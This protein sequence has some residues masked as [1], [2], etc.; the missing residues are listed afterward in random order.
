M[1]QVSIFSAFK[2]LTIPCFAAILIATGC[3]L[4]K[5]SGFNRG[6]QNITARYNILFNANEILRQKQESYATSFVDNYNEILSVYQ[7]T[8]PQTTTPDKDLELAIAK[9]N[10]IITIKEQSHYIGDAYLVLGK[11]NYLE[12]NYFNAVEYFSYVVRSFPKEKKLFQEGLIWKTR[13]LMYLNQ[14]A[15]A[16][17]VIDTA[18]QSINPKKRVNADIYA[19]KLQYDIDVQDYTDGE[20]MAKQAIRYC[21][22]ETQKLRWTFI[23]AQLQELNN[24]P[25]E[26]AANYS[27]IAK[28]NALFEMAFNASLNLIRIEDTQ[29]GVKIN[30]VDKLLGLLQN[31]N[32]KEFNDQIYYQAAQI[33]MAEKNIDQAIK[34][35]KLAIKA[36]VRN[37]DQKGLAYLR[38]AEI[39][40][41]NKA[42]YLRSKKYYDSTLTTLP[43]N[44]P[45]YQGIQKKS[46]NLALLA[47]RL[48]IITRED[49][50]QALARMDEKTRSALIDKMVDDE[51]LQQQAAANAAAGNASAGNSSGGPQGG[52]SRSGG[53]FYFDNATAVG[54]GFTDF[55]QKWGSRKPEDNW[56][57]STRSSS[58]ITANSAGS[59]Q[60]NDPDAP[61]NSA[62]N[63]KTTMNAGRY[64]KNLVQDLPL[65]PDLLAQSNVRVYNAYIDVG[66]FY[67]DI[68]DDKKEAI[69]T[70]ELVLRRFPDNPNNPAVYYSLYRLYSEVDP[71]KSDRYKNILLKNYAETPFAKIIS[72]PD[73]AKKLEDADAEFTQAYNI[74]FDL[75]AHKHYKEVIKSVPE[76]IKLY[77]DNKLS[78][79]LY[80]LRT[81]AAGH[82]EK[83]TPFRDSLQQ[84]T[85]KYPNDGLITPLVNK[86]LAYIDANQAELQA[87]NI[88]LENEDPNEVPFTLAQDLQEQAPYRHP[89]RPTPVFATKPGEGLPEKKPVAVA[90]NKPAQQVNVTPVNKPVI[91]KPDSATTQRQAVI[92]VDSVLTP[93]QALITKTDSVSKPDQTAINL[94]VIE[95]SIFSLNDST[96]YYFVVNVSSGTT[97]VAS[98]RFGIGQFNRANYAGKGI[99]HQLIV[100][101]GN[102]QLIF[103]GRFFSLDGVKDYARQII[104]LLPEIMKV[105]KDSYSFFII[106]QQ[107]LDKLA[108]KKTLDSYIDYY[109]KNY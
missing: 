19:T 41:N 101:E 102:N 109:Q 4:E 72:D 37:Q 36:G 46:S 34:Y 83:A 16:K 66:N 104:P 1:R 85:K 71:A 63:N 68:L 55:K 78:A 5:K 56:R 21:H 62:Q 57:R 74:V 7:D 15:E 25:R 98:S 92:K 58:D 64:R 17:P 9:G 24:K 50:L 94:P 100:V 32:N 47:D 23:L 43:T 73:Y 6:M 53:T 82:F 12:G 11:A 86:Q 18:I 67:R 81:I 90:A 54:Q 13:T 40:F 70:Y 28:S 3:S 84:L 31:P 45:G 69:S 107:N 93:G 29:N 42:D 39:Y 80:Y 35:Y 8:T 51:I 22:G 105:P 91:K 27:Q 60:A 88:V 96:N 10:R 76:L 79:Q 44:Y 103:V 52:I 48:Q 49:T 65:N 89:L 99:K 77:P 14:L 108:D 87:R 30:R 95:P 75:Y 26:A 61:V 33:Y 97:N 20:E 38:L 106:T 59:T 2:Y